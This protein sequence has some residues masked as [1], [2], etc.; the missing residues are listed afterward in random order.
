MGAT[1]VV[2]GNLFVADDNVGRHVNEVAENLAG[3][4]VG[5]AAHLLGDEAIESAGQNQQR[6]VEIHL[7]PH[8]RGKGVNMKETH[9]VGERVF[10]EHA[11]G[12]TGQQRFG[13]GVLLIGQQDGRF[14][15]AEVLDKDLSQAASGQGDALLEHARRAILAAGNIQFNG[16][17][18]RSGQKNDLF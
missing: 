12:I 13:G 3:L 9:R 6:H 7:E 15:V 18:S 5:V 11:L 1:M 2:H 10:N 17:P 8:R 16:S 4:G 14:I